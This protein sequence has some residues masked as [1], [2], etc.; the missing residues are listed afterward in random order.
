M[1]IR[2]Q[3]ELTTIYDADR[4]RLKSVLFD[5]SDSRAYRQTTYLSAEFL[6]NL[7]SS[8]V[9]SH[10]GLTP[11]KECM[12]QILEIT[13]QITHS[14]TGAVVFKG[15]ESVLVILPPFPIA[16]VSIHNDVNILP[17]TSLLDARPVVG[18]IFLRLGRYAVGV[19]RDDVLLAS[20]TGTRYVK[21]RHRKGGSSQRR[22]ERSRERLVREFYDKACSVASDVISPFRDSIDYLMFGGE[23]HTLNGFAKRCRFVRELEKKTLNRRLPV[24]R[25]GQEALESATKEIWV[26]KVLIF[27]K[28]CT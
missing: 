2:N 13:N 10:A 7:K 3:F 27:S 20:K 23:R 8:G 16:E 28:S 4:T 5:A 24:G 17:V 11:V 6:N 26:G 22:F 15:D 25:P 19:L 18:V 1:E 9:S 12:G 14:E 21:N